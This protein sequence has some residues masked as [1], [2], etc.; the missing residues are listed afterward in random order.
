[1]SL[2]EIAF[3]PDFTEF[4]NRLR[5]SFINSHLKEGA[6]QWDIQKRSQASKQFK[7][8]QRKER[9]NKGMEFWDQ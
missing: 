5:I 2:Q 6:E 3:N 7:K 1:M 9:M 4:I 8:D